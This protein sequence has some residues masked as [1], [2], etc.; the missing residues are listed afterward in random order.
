MQGSQKHLYERNLNYRDLK[1][2]STCKSCTNQFETDKLF[3]ER[4][5]LKF[6]EKRRCLCVF[7]SLAPSTWI[8]LTGVFSPSPSIVW[9]L[10]LATGRLAS[11][12]T[13][14]LY[15][16]PVDRVIQPV[17]KENAFASKDTGAGIELELHSLS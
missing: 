12:P 9:Q 4:Q 15:T 5:D 3:Y 7:S 8:S 6:S 2:F 14:H 16:G 10:S 11:S 13:L 1:S 17:R